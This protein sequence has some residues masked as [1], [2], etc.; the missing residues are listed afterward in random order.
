M[1]ALKELTNAQCLE[2]GDLRRGA[3][4]PQGQAISHEALYRLHFVLQSIVMYC[5]KQAISNLTRAEHMHMSLR[6]QTLPIISRS[7]G[8]LVRPL[9]LF[10]CP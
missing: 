3:P 2:H 4:L 8:L 9:L 5:G 10:A 1:P 6:L 7:R